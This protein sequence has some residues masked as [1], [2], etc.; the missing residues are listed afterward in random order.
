MS[1]VARSGQT[2]SGVSAR[3][4]DHFLG[5]LNDH[6][7]DVF[8][9]CTAN[10][11]S[12]LPPEF[13][14]AERF[15]GIFFLDLPSREQKDAIWRQYLSL[16]ELEASQAKPNDEM[17]TG[18]EIRACCRLAALLDVPLNAAA[19]NVVPVV[20]TAA[21]SVERLRNWASGRCLDADRVGIYQ[22]TTGSQP[23]RRRTLPALRYPA[24][25][26]DSSPVFEH[27]ASPFTVRPKL[28][29][30]SLPR[31]RSVRS[32]RSLSIWNDPTDRH[33]LFRTPNGPTVRTVPTVA[34]H[35][36]LGGLRHY[37]CPIQQPAIFGAAMTV[38]EAARAF[39]ETRNRNHEVFREHFDRRMQGLYGDRFW[40]LLSVF[41]DEVRA[42]RFV[43]RRSDGVARAADEFFRKPYAGHFQASS[44]K[45]VPEYSFDEAVQFARTWTEIVNRLYP[46]LVGVV[47][48]RS[49]DTFGDLLDSLPL[50][51]RELVA[52]AVEGE[53][54]KMRQLVRAVSVKCQEL[55]VPS[56]FVLHGENYVA[57]SLYEAARDYFARRAAG[58]SPR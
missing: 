36:F 12:K 9:V 39:V 16:F 3:L 24:S 28:T 33:G 11:V 30:S 22:R 55:E 4:F 17:W 52:K 57:S 34:Q 1:G 29:L 41:Q 7:S 47:T 2:D 40:Q 48:N 45:T 43:M 14:R 19:Q 42:F 51:G 46:A 5:W 15:D 35:L 20:K 32:G 50:L 6:T 25:G 31:Q 23:L 44:G 38:E 21:E 37:N 56:A 49:D 58:G 8:V 54:G 26:V 10:D 18:A 53:F 27:H 13:S